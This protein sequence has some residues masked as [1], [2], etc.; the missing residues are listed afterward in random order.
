MIIDDIPGK[1]NVVG[2]LC[3][4]HFDDQVY[5]IYILFSLVRL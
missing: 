3:S 1:Y 5:I 4:Q 2:Q